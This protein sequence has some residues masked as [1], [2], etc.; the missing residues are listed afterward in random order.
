MPKASRK[1][2][3]EDDK[4]ESQVEKAENELV[5]EKDQEDVPKLQARKGGKSKDPPT[6]DPSK[7]N[8]ATVPFPQKL[9]RN[10]LDAQFGKFLSYMKDISITLPFIDV[11]R[12]M[13]SWGKFLKDI[14]ARKGDFDDPTMVAFVQEAPSML[15]S[16]PQKCKDPGTFTIPCTIGQYGIQHALCDLGASVSL[17]P[18]EIFK[19]TGIGE[20][21]PTRIVLAMADKSLKYPLGVVEDVPTQVGKFVFLNDFV[22]VDMEVDEK[23]PILFGRPFLATAGALIDMKKGQIT[24]EANGEKRVFDM[25]NSVSSVDSIQDVNF[26]GAKELSHAVEKDDDIHKEVISSFEYC[27]RPLDFEV[28]HNPQTKKLPPYEYLLVPLHEITP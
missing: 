22:V 3:V 2:V 20:L 23:A 25:E 21:K 10:R 14:I 4:V 26:V 24:L 13:P 12:D 16:M 9:L 8:L 27:G 19:K 11:L 17:M 5:K 18:Y 28:Y 6:I 7:V 1:D 15:A